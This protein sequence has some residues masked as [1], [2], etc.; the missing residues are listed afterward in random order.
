MAEDVEARVTKIVTDE[1][2]SKKHD[3]EKDLSVSSTLPGGTFHVSFVSLPY[4]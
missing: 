3:R 1:R 4:R 2:E